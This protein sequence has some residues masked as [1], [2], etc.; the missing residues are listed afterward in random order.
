MIS[1]MPNAKDIAIS[2]TGLPCE[3]FLW[4]ET[5]YITCYK[6]IRGKEKNKA[7]KWDRELSKS[8]WG[9]GFAI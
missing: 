6:L 7:E 4:G 9:R 8:M 1:A 3:A 5:K 2:K